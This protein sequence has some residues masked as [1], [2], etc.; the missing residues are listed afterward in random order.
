VFGIPKDTQT[1]DEAS[2]RS[3]AKKMGL[4]CVN[5][6]P[7][8]QLWQVALLP[9]SV[10]ISSLLAAILARNNHGTAAYLTL[11]WG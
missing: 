5:R 3:P 11:F 10:A 7:S 6:S 8:C 2:F 1:T 4:Y 9:V